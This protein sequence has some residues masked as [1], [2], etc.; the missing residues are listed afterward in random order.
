MTQLELK[1]AIVANAEKEA[2]ENNWQVF[3]LPKENDFI[4][5]LIREVIFY[6]DRHGLYM[7]DG[8]NHNWLMVQIKRY[9]QSKADKTK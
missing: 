4:D 6:W 7:D 5:I 8:V 2:V 1:Q 9:E 3:E